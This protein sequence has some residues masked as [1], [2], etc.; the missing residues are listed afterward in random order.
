MDFDINFNMG[1]FF[2]AE[3]FLQNPD[4]LL[5]V[6]GT[7]LNYWLYDYSFAGMG[8][9]VQNLL[10]RVPQ[11]P[12]GLGKP[13]SELGQFMMDK[14]QI[15]DRSRVLFVGDTLEQD[16]GFANSNGFK[17][18]LVLSGVTTEKML[19]ELAKE[20]EVPDYYANSLH[21]FVEFYKE[22]QESKL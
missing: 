13:G 7:D 9:W 22:L 16:I 20:N 17:T 19:E 10:A 15:K 2:S 12:I 5:L 8:V 1:K 6:G 4:C 11:T 3:Y 18:L 14:F 21:D